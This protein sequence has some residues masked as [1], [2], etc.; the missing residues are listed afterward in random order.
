MTR[1]TI[2]ELVSEVVMQTATS[3]AAVILALRERVGTHV[4]TRLSDKEAVQVALAASMRDSEDVI[5]FLLPNHLARL[6]NAAR[7][8]YK[9]LPTEWNVLFGVGTQAVRDGGLSA[10]VSSK[11][12]TPQ[13]AKIA[14]ALKTTIGE[15]EQSAVWDRS[16]GKIL[17]FM[18]MHLESPE[19]ALLAVMGTVIKADNR[20]IEELHCCIDDDGP[21]V[22]LV[23][24][25]V[26]ALSDC[27]V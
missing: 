9:M 8:K 19:D 21:E 25:C 3:R 16:W 15:K 24:K 6:A 23:A 11:E 1:S 10:V 13:V 20:R 14:N 27:I 7:D 17:V 18:A 22:M 4:A 2:A 5:G 12:F 26:V